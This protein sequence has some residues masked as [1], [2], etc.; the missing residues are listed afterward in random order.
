MYNTYSHPVVTNCT[1][2]DNESTYGDGLYNEHSSPMVTNCI[3]WDNTTT[4]ISNGNNCCPVVTYSCVEDTYSGTGNISSDPKLNDDYSISWDSSCIDEGNNDIVNVG[5]DITGGLRRIDDL[6]TTDSGNGDSRIVDMGAYEYAWFPTELVISAGCGHILL[7]KTDRSVWVWGTEYGNTGML[8]IGPDPYGEKRFP[9]PVWGSGEALTTTGLLEGVAMADA[10]GEFSLAVDIDG[11]A[12][13]WGDSTYGQLGNP[14]ATDTDI[15]GHVSDG[16]M[17]TT[18]DVLE[19]IVQVA[20]S[21]QA[22]RAGSSL[23][24]DTSGNVWGWGYNYHGHLGNG[25]SGPGGDYLEDIVDIDICHY[26]AVALDNTTTSGGYVWNWGGNWLGNGSGE[27][28]DEPVKVLKG[29][30]DCT[31]SYLRDI[32]DVCVSQMDQPATYALSYS[33]NVYA[34]GDGMDGELGNNTAGGGG[35]TTPVQVHG[36]EQ[37]GDVLE[38]IVDISGFGYG[39]MALED[40]DDEPESGKDGRVYMWGRDYGGVLGNG[41]TS[42]DQ[43]EPVMVLKAESTP[44]TDIVYIAVFNVRNCFAIDRYGKIWAWGYNDM[45]QLGLGHDDPTYYATPIE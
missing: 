14:D 41:P 8:G 21:L 18:S 35:S 1:F 12:W 44:L 32:I 26:T 2:A 36:G 10:G 6:Y 19:N 27:P 30:M 9:V 17:S 29:Q 22:E 11:F 45:Y 4:D 5:M 37:G 13:S 20:A 42:D 31:G 15:P 34:W 25:K 28:S 40:L 38:D 39:C 16:E 23:A 7:T 3:F 43:G 24:L 33:H